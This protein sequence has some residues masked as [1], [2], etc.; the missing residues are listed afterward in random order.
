MTDSKWPLGRLP[1]DL[2]TKQPVQAITGAV[3]HVLRMEILTVLHQGEFSAGEIADILNEDV[4]YVNGHV[5]TLMETGCIEFMGFRRIGGHPRAVFRAI[6]LPVVTDEDFRRMAKAERHDGS[7]AIVQG[8]TAESLSAFANEKLDNAEEPPCLI[9]DAPPLDAKRRA[10][11]R[12]R[13]T[14][15]W[16]EEVLGAEA[17]TVNEASET[18][19]EA[20]PT[21]VGLFCFERGRRGRPESGYYRAPKP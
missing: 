7:G 1:R 15:V 16:V 5:T 13:L 12:K 10:K 3:N 18:G 9:W 8:F 2:R 20:V 21:V 17:E 4:R 19:E 6:T 14:E 11:L